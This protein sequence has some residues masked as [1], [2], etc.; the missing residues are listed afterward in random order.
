MIIYVPEGM[1]EASELI[2]RGSAIVGPPGHFD[3]DEI[4]I[5]YEGNLHGASNLTKWEDRLLSAAGRAY[6][7]YPTSAK[8]TVP[9]ALLQP[10]GRI[11]GSPGLWQVTIYPT[12]QAIMALAE[13]L[14]HR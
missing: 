14:T 6:E 10:V 2:V 9:Y 4:T 1:D 13:W 3:D 12:E 5:H 8:M 11:D 7:N